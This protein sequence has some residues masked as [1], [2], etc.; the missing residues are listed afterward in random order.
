M[1]N[2]HRRVVVTGLGV[3]SPVGLTISDMWEALVSGQSGVDYISLVSNL[4]Y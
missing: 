2:N 1:L 4:G 3:I